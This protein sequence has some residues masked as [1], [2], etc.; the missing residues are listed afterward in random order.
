MADPDAHINGNHAEDFEIMKA[1]K[2]GDTFLLTLTENA[3]G[4]S[5]QITPGEIWTLKLTVSA[6]NA[7]PLRFAVEVMIENNRI[8]AWSAS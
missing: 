2:T 3:T 6:D 8:V 4:G 7:D 1:S 5:S